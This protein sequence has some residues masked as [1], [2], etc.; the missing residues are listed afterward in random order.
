MQRTATS[1]RGLGAIG[2]SLGVH[3]LAG[4]VLWLMPEPPPRAE[5]TAALTWID[6]PALVVQPP[7]APPVRVEPPAPSRTRPTKRSS[8]TVAS[9][10]APAP[11]PTAGGTG[12]DTPLAESGSG[13]IA[14]PSK[15]PSLVPRAGFVMSMP[16]AY[17]AEDSRG[18]TLHNEPMDQPDEVAVREY[19]AEK[20]GRKLSLDLATD[21]AR[22]QQGAGRLPG[23]F[24][25]VS[26]SLEEAAA[27]EKVAVSK[28]SER[29]QA[30]N[31]LGSV[32]DPT[33]T[34]P[35]DTAVQRVAE[36]AFVQNARI[37][38]PA[39]PGDQQQFNQA[40]AQSFT[41]LESI[42]DQLSA[43]RLRTVV[44]LTTDPRGVLADASISERSGD[45]TFDESALHLSRKVMRK[46]PESDEK[47]LGTSWWRSRWVFTW[48]P[49]RMKVR[50]LEATP[51]PP[52][53]PLE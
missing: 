42:K 46:L 35:T 25:S 52:P 13:P 41:R 51:L 23:F 9:P 28:D 1:R 36:T 17:D 31:A 50:L 37:G 26:R 14:A 43:P 10:A 6:V 8:T 21:V 18:T 16:E 4:V 38:N 48:E 47:A 5:A 53:I 30:L 15:R 7:P 27:N 19:E 45:R 29:A 12:I 11:A 3:A 34:K 2:L 22:A 39:L 32:L 49:P 40:V 24:G 20:A 33:R 44:T